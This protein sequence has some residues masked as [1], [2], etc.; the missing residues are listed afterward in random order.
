MPK[1]KKTL[2]EY[3]MDWSDDRL[4]RAVETACSELKKDRKRPPDEDRHAVSLAIIHFLRVEMDRR[5]LKGRKPSTHEQPV[6]G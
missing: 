5:G 1:K 2:K 3:V 6:E 4:Q